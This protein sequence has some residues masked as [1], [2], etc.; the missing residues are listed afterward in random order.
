MTRTACHRVS[1]FYGSGPILGGVVISA[2]G[3]GGEDG[4]AADASTGT[5]KMIG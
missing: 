4:V 5:N 3:A 2:A 1:I